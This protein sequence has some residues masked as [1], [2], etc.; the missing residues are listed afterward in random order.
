MSNEYYDHT[1][2][3]APNAPGASAA[4]RAEFEKVEQGFEKMP[5]LDGKAN[6]PIAVKANQLGLEAVDSLAVNITGNVT[7]DVTGNVTGTLTGNVTAATG[8]SSFNNITLSGTLTGVP[9]PVNNNDAANKAYVDG[10]AQGLVFKSPARAATTANITL[11]GTQT[12][13]G[14]ALVAGER[15][16]VKNQTT[17]SQNGVYV[18]ASGA[19]SRSADMNEWTELPRAYLFVEDGT[20][21][22]N[23]SWV[24][25]VVLGGTIGTTPITFE[26][27]AGAGEINAGDGLTKIGS[28]L[29]VGTA[30]VSRIVV[31][32]NDID[33]APS[34]VTPG[35]YNKFTVDLYGR[36]TEATNDSVANL[37]LGAKASDPTVDNQGGPLVVGAQYFNTTTNQMRVY[38]TSS[39]WTQ[40]GTAVN[41]TATRVIYTA[42]AGQTSFAVNYNVGF[43]DVYRNGLK[44][45]LGTQVIA[46]T[47]TSIIL[48][49]GATA[50][51]TIDIVAYGTFV[52]SNMLPL[53]GGTMT[54]PITLAAD[55]VNSLQPATKQ[56]VDTAAGSSGEAF[57]AF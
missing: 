6:K 11:S 54:G 50:G 24:C 37:Y 22:N 36:V 52:L 48:A 31:N 4:L 44:L 28:T 51:D 46:T 13:D 5:A 19:W 25:T 23:A 18:V 8:T 7:G 39:I 26:Q 40:A 53:A 21:N 20:A 9:S 34:G 27:F 10:L 15:V 1:T 56:Y 35:A 30:S 42:T 12:I 43:V 3:P 33:L 14:I 32:A 55:P 29:N 38:T 41:G 16:L 47:G 45:T 2:Y 57:S 17:Q 49:T